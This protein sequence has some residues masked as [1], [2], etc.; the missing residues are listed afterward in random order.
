MLA[1][2]IISTVILSILLLAI[3]GVLFTEFYKDEAGFI[4]TII[5]GLIFVIITLWIL[6]VR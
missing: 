6:Y 4:L 1:I 5:L 3:T 2:A